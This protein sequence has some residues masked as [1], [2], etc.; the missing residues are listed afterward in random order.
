MKRL[1]CEMC[2]STDLIKQDNCF[3]CQVCG[4]KYSV[5]EAKKMMIEG[6]VEVQG[7]VQLDNS[8]FVK[9]Y[10]ENARRARAKEDWEETEKYYNLVEQNDPNNLEAIF[11]S[12]YGKARASLVDQDIYKREAVFKVLANCISIIDDKYDV[13]RRDENKEAIMEIAKALGSMIGAQFVYTTWKNGYGIVV[14]D[15]KNQTYA[16]FGKLIDAFRE[17]IGNISRVDDQAYIHEA[18]IYLYKIAKVSG[19]GNWHSLMTKWIDEEERKILALKQRA[20]KE[21]WEK[22]AD[23]KEQFESELKELNTQK[24]NYIKILNE[25]EARTENVPAFSQLVEV[26]KNIARLEAEKSSLGIFKGKEKKAIQA[27][28]DALIDQKNRI[29]GDVANQRAQIRNELASEVSSNK[30]A[31]A[32]VAERIRFINNEFTKDRFIER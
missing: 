22:H 21:Y 4:C 13:N 12:A 31:L 14:K 25:L 9:K 30:E 27:Q 2:G 7:T 5:E 11:F 10:L 8:S 18:S 16:L 3:V 24:D 28:I 26:Q 29:Q 20:I 23:E 1:T 32:K 17:S 6:T 19:I 15:N